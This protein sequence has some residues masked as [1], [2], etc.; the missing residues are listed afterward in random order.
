M[1]SKNFRKLALAMII[2]VPMT[3]CSN[4]SDDVME[5]EKPNTA[6]NATT[7]RNSASTKAGAGFG[8]EYHEAQVMVNCNIASTNPTVAVDT[9]VLK[10]TINH[11]EVKVVTDE[12]TYYLHPELLAKV[13]EPSYSNRWSS[14]PAGLD[15]QQQPVI[16]ENLV[17]K[18]KR[19]F[20]A[21]ATVG[22]TVRV[23]DPNL[24]KGYTQHTESIAYSCSSN[25][26]TDCSADINCSLRVTP[27]NF[28]ADVNNYTPV[29]FNVSVND[30]TE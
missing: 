16:K 6:D 29:E 21:H 9:D 5:V 27:V 8:Q 22:C 1:I 25:N 3:S 24:A 18:Y 14:L 28:D 10:V 2:A 30:Y 7:P 17:V 20:E 12:D 19:Y 26:L 13:A 23:K 4:G 11:V 15:V